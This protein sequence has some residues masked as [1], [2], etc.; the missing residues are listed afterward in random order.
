LRLVIDEGHKLSKP[1]DDLTQFINQ[2]AAE[3]WWVLLGMPMTGIE[4]DPQFISE[5]LD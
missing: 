3:R 1:V 4:D 5:A 2:I